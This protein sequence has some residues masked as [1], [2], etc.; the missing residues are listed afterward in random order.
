MPMWTARQWFLFA[1]VAA[2][3]FATGV[4]GFLAWRS[5][6]AGDYGHAVVDGVLTLAY[7]VGILVGTRGLLD[8]PQPPWVSRLILL[9]VLLLPAVRAL[10]D[11]VKARQFVSAA[12]AILDE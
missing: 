12:E 5:L 9:A 8:I 1:D 4:F 3:I 10:R 7:G 6:R 2:V 11:W